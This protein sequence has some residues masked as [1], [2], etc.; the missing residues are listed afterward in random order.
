MHRS[1][2]LVRW[3]TAKDE[4]LELYGILK[5]EKHLGDLCQ[6][7]GIAEIGGTKHSGQDGTT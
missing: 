5:R 4:C 1:H 3:Y 6:A 7:S 2:T